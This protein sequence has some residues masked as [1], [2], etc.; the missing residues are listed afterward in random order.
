[1]GQ[2]KAWQ[3]ICHSSTLEQNLHHHHWCIVEVFLCL[4]VY[5]SEKNKRLVNDM[6]NWWSVSNKLLSVFCVLSTVLKGYNPKTQS[7]SSRRL[8]HRW[9]GKTHVQKLS[10]RKEQHQEEHGV[11]SSELACWVAAH[12]RLGQPCLLPMLATLIPG[13]SWS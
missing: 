7:L 10:V 6:A 3:W 12:L 8:Q 13:P 2:Y 11:V 9:G 4:F 5:S 1:M